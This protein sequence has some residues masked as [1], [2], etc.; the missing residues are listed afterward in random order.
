[1]IYSIYILVRVLVYRYHAPAGDVNVGLSSFLSLSLAPRRCFLQFIFSIFFLLRDKL[2]SIPVRLL[3]W[4]TYNRQCVIS[5]S[6]NLFLFVLIE[7]NKCHPNPC[8]NGGTCTG[9][10]EG[11]GFEC[12]CRE[13]FKGKNCEGEDQK[14]YN[15]NNS[16]RSFAIE[17]RVL[18]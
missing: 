3:I 17:V 12:T 8:R 11:E 1:M 9:I 10:N 16:T 7:Q 4:Q 13:G 15:N 2:F 5:R 6:S 14:H 18:S